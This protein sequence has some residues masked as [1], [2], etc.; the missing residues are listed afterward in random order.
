[1]L[2]IQIYSIHELSIDIKLLVESSTVTNTYG[3]AVSV[4][5]KMPGLPLVP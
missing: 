3:L 4:S 5:G 2:V 1:M